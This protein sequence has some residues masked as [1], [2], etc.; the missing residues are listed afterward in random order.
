MTEKKDICTCDKE[1]CLPA[2]EKSIYANL[3]TLVIVPGHGIYFGADQWGGTF[4]DYDETKLL[5]EH[6]IAGV[7]YARNDSQSLLMFSGGQTRLECGQISEAFGY[8]QYVQENS[9][10]LGSADLGSRLALEEFA[11]DSFE[12]LLFSIHRFWQCTGEW[13]DKVLVKGYAFKEERFKYH[14][15]HLKRNLEHFKLGKGFEFVYDGINDPPEQILED[16]ID[17]KT[18]KVNVGVRKKEDRTLE[19]FKAEAGERNPPSDEEASIAIK[20]LEE[21]R[22]RRD[23]FMRGNPYYGAANPRESYEYR[24]N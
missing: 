24:L 8:L 21:K 12:N 2:N 15:E 11:R 13:P 16:S 19:E 18:K 9:G 17:E 23:R 20:T 14:A 10:L 5:V 6:I 7:K 3:K 4:T 22:R 1:N